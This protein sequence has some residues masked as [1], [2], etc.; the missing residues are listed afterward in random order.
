[1][2]AKGK[3]GVGVVY[4]EPL[5]NSLSDIY[6]FLYNFLRYVNLGKLFLI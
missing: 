4:K 3:Q 1:M 5:Q 2:G 6:I